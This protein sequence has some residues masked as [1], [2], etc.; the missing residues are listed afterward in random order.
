MSPNRGVGG[1]VPSGEVKSGQ[2]REVSMG[3]ASVPEKVLRQQG[4]AEPAR[5]SL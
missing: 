1:A 4:F 3:A 2:V 5:R